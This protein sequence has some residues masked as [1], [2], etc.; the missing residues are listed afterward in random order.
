MTTTPVDTIPIG[1]AAEASAASLRPPMRETGAGPQGAA[2]E[3]PVHLVVE[4]IERSP[5]D[6]GVAVTGTY[7]GVAAFLRRSG[8]ERI[9]ARLDYLRQVVDEDPEHPP[10]AIESLRAL[11]TFL[12][13]ERQLPHP[14]ISVGED[15]LLS[16]QWRTASNDRM[17]M[18]FHAPGEV[19]FAALSSP[20]DPRE[21]LNVSGT[22][23][24]RRVM[25]AVK[26]FLM[27]MQR[28]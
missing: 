28:R 19:R 27:R 21:Q 18:E 26:P 12:V 11:A 22:S 6:E 10:M 13:A 5:W 15:G 7:E 1:P 2:P 4:A 24:S 16:A 23:P 8:L 3:A 9:A 25:R 14:Q 20:G 17:A